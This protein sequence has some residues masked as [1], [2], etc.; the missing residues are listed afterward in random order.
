MKNA[1][2]CIY[3]DDFSHD[4]S[5]SIVI[6]RAS[7][8][9]KRI[10]L[11]VRGYKLSQILRTALEIGQFTLLKNPRTYEEIDI[12]LGTAP[13]LTKIPLDA[14][15]SLGLVGKNGELYESLD[16]AKE[17]LGV[18]SQFYQGHFIKLELSK[19]NLWNCLPQV[20]QKKEEDNQRTKPTDKFDSLHT[21][22]M[23]KV[24]M[25]RS[26]SLVVE[27]LLEVVLGFKTAKSMFDLDGGHG[28]YSIALT[29]AAPKL[30]SYVLDLPQV[31]ELAKEFIKTYKAESRINTIVG[32]IT[33][34]EL[35]N[36]AYDIIF[37]SHVLY[38][39]ICNKVIVNK[40]AIAFNYNIVFIINQ[41]MK[42][43]KSDL[44]SVLWDINL[45]LQGNSEFALLTLDEFKL[46]LK[47]SNL[48]I[49]NIIE[50]GNSSAVT[51][52]IVERNLLD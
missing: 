33:H 30:S 10:D 45:V 24:A 8:S 29:Q 27:T 38:R 31:I 40:I 50:K 14:L 20:L 51:T 3:M 41:W 4:P 42:K 6:L 9:P 36:E 49:E 16:E 46:L 47:E 1:Y 19:Y 21:I 17:F 44:S 22:A 5:D 11:L 43:E 23:A 12:K 37:A 48:Y 26:L 7:C 15:V 35:G 28:L 18:D 52:I 39:D 32:D 2:L 13:K 34:D 25:R